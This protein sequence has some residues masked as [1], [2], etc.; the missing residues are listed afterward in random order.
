[1][2]RL[3]RRFDEM[4]G[5]YQGALPTTERTAHNEL[6]LVRYNRHKRNLKLRECLSDAKQGLAFLEE[7][8]DSWIP[9]PPSLPLP[10]AEEMDLNF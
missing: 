1:M 3:A 9:V 4:N 8:D 10:P 7:P 5:G 2:S 6:G